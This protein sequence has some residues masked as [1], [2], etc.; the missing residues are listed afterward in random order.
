MEIPTKEEMLSHYQDLVRRGEEAGSA[1]N[2]LEPMLE[3][4]INS[5]V[6]K[7]ATQ[8]DDQTINL[9]ADLRAWTGILRR[10]THD[11]NEGARARTELNKF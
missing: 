8:Y 1:L 7:V 11:M 2:I 4:E 3:R 6:E 10:L 9:L 5:L